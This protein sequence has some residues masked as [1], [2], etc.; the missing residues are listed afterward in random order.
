MKITQAILTTKGNEMKTKA[1]VWI[2]HDKAV[3][4]LMADGGEELKTIE[5]NVE[6]PFASA[7]GPG[8]KH[9]DRPHGH[10]TENTQEHKFMNELNTY[11][12]EVLVSLRGADSVLILGPGEAKGEFQKRLESKK[13]P[14]S[15]VELK[16]A[17]RLTDHQ[18]AV[19]VREHFAK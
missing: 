8:S 5:S 2:D 1:G 17:D 15:V 4:V 18:I 9:P 13:F 7:G 11:Y 14:A 6:K 19:S 3:V 12:D 16:T 10:M